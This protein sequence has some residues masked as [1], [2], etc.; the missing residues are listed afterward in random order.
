MDNKPSS[1]YRYIRF[2]GSLTSDLGL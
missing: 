1:I 2:I